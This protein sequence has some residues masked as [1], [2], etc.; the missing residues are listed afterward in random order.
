MD[1]QLGVVLVLAIPVIT[2]ASTAGITRL[3]RRR[4]GNRAGH[5][6]N[7]IG[8][9]TLVLFGLAGAAGLGCIAFTLLV[10]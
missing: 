3:A 9:A 7:A 2:I 4:P 8:I 5:I 10:V 6:W 1:R